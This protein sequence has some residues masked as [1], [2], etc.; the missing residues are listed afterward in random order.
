MTCKS[1]ETLGEVVES[2]G[3]TTALGMKPALV[4]LAQT[5]AHCERVGLFDRSSAALNMT[6]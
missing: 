3:E 2:G 1:D 6:R 5:E 4:A